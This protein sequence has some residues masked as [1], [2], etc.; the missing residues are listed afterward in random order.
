MLMITL[1]TEGKEPCV[2]IASGAATG[3]REPA[4]IQKA[5]KYAMVDG[6]CGEVKGHRDVQLWTLPSCLPWALQSPLN[7]LMH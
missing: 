1:G 4:E 3:C 5:S 7:S 6:G 2:V